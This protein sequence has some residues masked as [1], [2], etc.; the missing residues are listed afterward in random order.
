MI[1]NIAAAAAPPPPGGSPLILLNAGPP[2]P[3]RPEPMKPGTYIRKRRIAAGL[4]IDK[5]ALLLGST[6]R[7]SVGVRNQLI[8]MEADQGSDH[9]LLVTRLK[10]A[11]PFDPYVYFALVD[12]LADPTLP[13][14]QICRSCACTWHDACEDESGPCAWVSG[15]PDL[16]TACEGNEPADAA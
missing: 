4:E 16:C 8:M 3:S 6:R 5:V 11:F 13:A 9:G 2:A 12:V 7:D 10:D 15:E 14:P 1:E